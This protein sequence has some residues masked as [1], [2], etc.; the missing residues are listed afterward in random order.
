MPSMS[1]VPVADSG[2]PRRR[3]LLALIAVV[4]VI[5]VKVRSA[6]DLSS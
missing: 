1:E 6:K 5:G 2:K 4:P 3:Q